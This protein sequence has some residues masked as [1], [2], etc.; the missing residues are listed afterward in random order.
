MAPQALKIA[1]PDTN[2]YYYLSY[3]QPLGFDANLSSFYLGG[4]NVHRYQ[5]SG[6]V[7]TYFLDSLLDGESFID[8]VNGITITQIS[9][10]DVNVT[11]QVQMDAT[12]VTSAPIA[13]ISPASRSAPAGTTLAYTVAVSNSDSPNCAESNFSLNAALP[14]GWTGSISPKTLPLSPGQSGTATLTVTSPVG[15][16]SASYGFTVNVSGAA[17]TGASYVVEGINEAD[18]EAP[19]V[20]GGLSANLKGKNVKLTW[21]ASTDNVGVSGYAV[22]RDGARIG[23]TAETGFVDSSVPSGMTCTYTVSAYDVSGNDSPVSSAA[24]VTSRGGSRGGGKGKPKK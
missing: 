20:P 2:E 21:I 7:Q 9:H 24:S 10:S 8:A 3:R 6:A 4:L 11:I 1:K 19:T 16:A 15:A 5:G 18:T 13:D 23:D 14:D 17:P 22:W 12:C